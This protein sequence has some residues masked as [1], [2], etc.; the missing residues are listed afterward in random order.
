MENVVKRRGRKMR[1]EIYVK[2]EYYRDPEPWEN[3]S[4]SKNYKTEE[5][6]VKP[7]CGAIRIGFEGKH[8]YTE[9]EIK[10]NVHISPA[11]KKG[12]YY[13]ES[14]LRPVRWEYYFHAS[15]NSNNI[16]TKEYGWYGRLYKTP[17]EAKEGFLKTWELWIKTSYTRKYVKCYPG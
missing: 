12:Y 6:Y 4:G 13:F 5:L 7:K 9:E 11:T 14:E 1:K 10:F 8:G 17:E 2:I 3:W 15:Y 16:I